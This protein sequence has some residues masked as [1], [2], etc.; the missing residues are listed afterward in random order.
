MSSSLGIKLDGSMEIVGDG[1]VP[2]VKI[3]SGSNR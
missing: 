3:I 1:R 2:N